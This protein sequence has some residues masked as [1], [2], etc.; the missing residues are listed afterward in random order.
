MGW[1]WKNAPQFSNRLVDPKSAWTSARL[2]RRSM[3]VWTSPAPVSLSG[4]TR[5]GG[6]EGETSPQSRIPRVDPD[7]PLFGVPQDARRRGGPHRTARPW[8]EVFG[9]VRYS[10]VRKAPPDRG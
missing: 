10:L 7:P 3:T 5:Y 1:R 4:G 6:A 9:S 8:P 2:R